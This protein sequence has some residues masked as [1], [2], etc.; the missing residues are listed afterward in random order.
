MFGSGSRKPVLQPYVDGNSEVER[1]G[2]ADRSTRACQTGEGPRLRPHIK[3]SGSFGGIYPARYLVSFIILDSLA[4]PPFG[5]GELLIA[6][7][8]TGLHGWRPFK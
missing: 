4:L 7:A 1:Q 6:L 8:C 3:S 2:W 5:T